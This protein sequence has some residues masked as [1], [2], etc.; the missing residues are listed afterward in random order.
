VKKATVL[1]L[2]ATPEGV[3][4]GAVRHE[5]TVSLGVFRPLREGQPV[6][7]PSRVCELADQPGTPFLEATFPF[8]E[9][10]EPAEL[11]QT[12]GHKGPARVSSAA[13]HAAWERIFGGPR[14]EA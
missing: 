8:A 9:E 3:V 6:L 11:A 2:G 10:P 7:D 4:A 13:Y 1:P 14:G 5:D 12:G